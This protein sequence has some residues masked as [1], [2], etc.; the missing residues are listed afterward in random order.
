MCDAF[1]THQDRDRRAE[2]K[3]DCGHSSSPDDITHTPYG[4]E[5][6]SGA[7]SVESRILRPQR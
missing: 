7:V 1:C 5:M 4:P 3:A 2:S 6:G